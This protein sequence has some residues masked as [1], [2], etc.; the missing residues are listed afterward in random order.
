MRVREVAA[1]RAWQANAVHAVAP[2]AGRQDDLAQE[3]ILKVETHDPVDPEDP[4]AGWVSLVRPQITYPLSVVRKT[5][6][7]YVVK[8]KIYR[9]RQPNRLSPTPYPLSDVR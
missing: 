4:G 7:S 2:A 1:W 5:C 8:S 6:S 3:W 9:V